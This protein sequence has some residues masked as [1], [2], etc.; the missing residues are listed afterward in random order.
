M[1]NNHF[2][3]MINSDAT[4]AKHYLL[5]VLLHHFPGVQIQDSNITTDQL[6]CII[7]AYNLPNAVN[8][9]SY[10]SLHN[11]KI[12]LI[13][14]EPHGTTASFAHLI[15]DCKRDS[16]LRPKNVPFIYLPFYVMSFA[17]RETA[18][19]TDLLCHSSMPIKTKFCAFMYSNP[20]TFRDELFDAL[21]QYKSVDALGSCRNSQNKKRH[22]TDRVQYDLYKKTYYEL[23]V[24]KYKPYKFVIACEN[25]RINGYI[26]EKLINAV[27][28]RCVP[29]YLG[30]PDIFEDGVFNPKSMI[31][32]A[33]F[34]SYTKCA[35]YVKKVDQ[36]EAL[37]Y[38]YL[39]EPLFVNNK[40]P[41]YFDSDYILNDFVKVFQNK[42]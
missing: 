15:I 11:V 8:V 2:R 41:K 14:G 18:Q 12:I 1:S 31:H 9:L 42:K 38:Q 26:T 39:K 29:I 21:N 5:A 40:L 23:A 32:V 30:A 25:S 10:E 20:V 19:P 24:E 28:A 7:D 22:E 6:H 34:P 37:Y 16:S 27:L 13:T 35:E 3:V 33:D 36:D 4:W 17:E